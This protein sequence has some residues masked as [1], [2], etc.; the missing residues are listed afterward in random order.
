MPSH[1]KTS[2]HAH[3][4]RRHD[5]T[6]AGLA[7]HGHP[8]R[9]ATG[10]CKDPANFQVGYHYVKKVKGGRGLDSKTVIE[11][12]IVIHARAACERHARL[13]AFKKG[14]TFPKAA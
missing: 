10:F 1:L 5:F 3:F 9:C 12:K 13:W 6:R 11:P 7:D 8:V 4:V 2:A 14:L